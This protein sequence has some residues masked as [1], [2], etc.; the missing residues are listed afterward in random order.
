MERITVRLRAT[1]TDE[2]GATLYPGERCSMPY[3]VARRMMANGVA[4]EIVPEGRPLRAA[5][6][7]EA[8]ATK[9]ILDPGELKGIAKLNWLR[10]EITARGGTPQGRSQAALEAQLEELSGNG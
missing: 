10:A 4:E 6:L 8:P 7:G 3:A 2:K 9:P 5:G 1:Y